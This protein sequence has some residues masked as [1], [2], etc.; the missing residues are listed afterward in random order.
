MATSRAAS[1]R[2]EELQQMREESAVGGGQ[3]RIDQQH[4]KGKL[5]ARER[6]ALLMDRGSFQEIDSFV[7]HRATDFGMDEKHYYRR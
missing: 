4:D 6:I 1:Q 7:T 2:L 3:N 5:T